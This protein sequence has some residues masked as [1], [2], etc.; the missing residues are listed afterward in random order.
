MEPENTSVTVSKKLINSARE[1][2]EKRHGLS[3]N[4]ITNIDFVKYLLERE[5]IR[6]RYKRK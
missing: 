4:T 1:S 2:F 3:H 5:E 6:N